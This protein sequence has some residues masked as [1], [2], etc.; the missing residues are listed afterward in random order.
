MNQY[1]LDLLFHKYVNKTNGSVIY[2]RDCV[3]RPDMTNGEQGYLW[4][5]PDGSYRHS[6]H[7]PEMMD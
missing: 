3:I 7:T 5:Y 6:Y 2:W 1:Q 4:V